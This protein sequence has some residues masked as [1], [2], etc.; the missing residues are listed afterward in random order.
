MVSNLPRVTWLVQDRS[1]IYTQGLNTSHFHKENPNSDCWDGDTGE[2][3]TFPSLSL[4]SLP[5]VELTLG[6]TVSQMAFIKTVI[7]FPIWC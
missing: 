3:E 5:R 7:L 2:A 6:K 4:P 1:R